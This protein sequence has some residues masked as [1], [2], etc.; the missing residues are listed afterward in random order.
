MTKPAVPGKTPILNPHATVPHRLARERILAIAWLALALLPVGSARAGTSVTLAWSPVTNHAV[1]GYA[2]YEGNASGVYT[3][4]HDA[5]TNTSITITG[6]KAGQTNFFVAT[7]YNAD[8]QESAPSVEVAYL[9]PGLVRL[10]A[11]AKPGAPVILSFP[12]AVGHSY[13]IQASTNL[14]TWT[15]LA[16]TAVSTSNAWFSYQDGTASGFS[17]C[18]YRLI[19]N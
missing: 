8:L 17:R 2:L 11:P 4:R 19:L 1:A 14:Q 15:N 18:F 7:D 12:V 13:E 6:L 10:T 9:V 3:S 16:Q 5:G